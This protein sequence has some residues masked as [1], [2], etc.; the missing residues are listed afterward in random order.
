MKRI[1]AIVAALAC[2]IGMAGTPRAE[3]KTYGYYSKTYKVQVEYWFF[4]TE[5][6]HW[7]TVFE[8]SDQAEA[9]FV[10]NAL[11]V[12]KQNGALNAAAPNSYWRYIAVDVRL[13]SA[14]TFHSTASR[15]QA[16]RPYSNLRSISP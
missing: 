9:Q 10:Y 16:A 3:A 11:L 12:A 13:V 15:Y 5:S 6:Y 7:S 2:G 1:L 4:D 14:W 8:S